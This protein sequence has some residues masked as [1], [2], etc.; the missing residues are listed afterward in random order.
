[1]L[2]SPIALAQYARP[3]DERGG[4]SPS[5]TPPSNGGR[6]FSLREF[7]HDEAFGGILLLICALMALG[8]A[9]SS[10]KGSYADLWSAEVTLGTVHFNL[11]ETLK[12]WVNDGLMAIFFFVVG[13]EI[14]REVLV[15]ELASP[16]RAALPAIAALGG[17]VVPA[18]IY[19]LLNRGQTGSEGWGIPMATDIAFALGVLAL[20]GDRVPIGLK[21]FLTAL[22]IVD[23]I[24]AVLVI[25]LFYTSGVDWSALAAAAGVLVLLVIANRLGVRQTWVYGGL[26]L[27]LWVAVFESGIHATVAGVLLAMTIPA[28]TRLDPDRFLTRGRALLDHFDRAG[29]HGASVLTNGERQE[30]LAELEA[31]V[32]GAGAPLQRLEHSL[33]P[34]VA[35]AIVPVFALAN[36]GV[37]IEGGVADAVGNRV[38]LGVVLGLVLGKQLGI[39]VAAWAAV[40]L[41]LTDLPEG[42]SQREIYAVSWLAGI[43][44]TMSLFVADLA[45]AGAGGAPL[46]TS[47]KVGILIA[48][49]LAGCMGWV[50]L[51]GSRPLPDVERKER[52]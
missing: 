22:A 9:N 52:A 23:D 14:K 44:F 41:G 20:L 12:H 13:L 47:A 42:V 6:S 46:L 30:A 35:F 5:E 1:M 26:G 49:V 36:A 50:L 39:T 32:E 34:L 8:W 29:E 11:T 21:V 28:S 17:V 18:G 27:L 33:H 19:L 38:T 31:A 45:F 37:A 10:W 43:G 3:L 16:R 4:S 15:G 7:V 51:R 40:R 2:S 48:S 24:A 25:A